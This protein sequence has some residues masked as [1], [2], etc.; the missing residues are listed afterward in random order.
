M[1]SK[2]VLIM[3][4]E[5]FTAFKFSEIEFGFEWSEFD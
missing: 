3:A 5:F 2:A 1:P 4:I